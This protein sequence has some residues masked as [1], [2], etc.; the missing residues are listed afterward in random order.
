MDT[1]VKVLVS[2]ANQMC[3]MFNIDFKERITFNKNKDYNRVFFLKSSFLFAG[4]SR[5]E[6]YSELD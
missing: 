6:Q 1:S 3:V 4:L 2:L 5:A